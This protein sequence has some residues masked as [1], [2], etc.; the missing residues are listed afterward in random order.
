MELL[1]IRAMAVFIVAQLPPMQ[2]DEMLK[3]L[4]SAQ[5]LVKAWYCQ[6]GEILPFPA[7]MGDSPRAVA[8]RKDNPSGIP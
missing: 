3:V 5:M 6:S 8:M 1:E 4:V 2:P 7:P